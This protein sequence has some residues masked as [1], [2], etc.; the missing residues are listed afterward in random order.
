MTSN[1]KKQMTVS[2]KLKK[3]LYYSIETVWYS[4]GLKHNSKVNVLFMMTILCC[5][6]GGYH[7][8]DHCHLFQAYSY[9]L[10]L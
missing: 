4:L 8:S 5:I 1:Q 10:W 3:Y 7:L 6:F 9:N 2:K